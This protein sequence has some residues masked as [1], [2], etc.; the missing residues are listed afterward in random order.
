MS[1]RQPTPVPGRARL[2]WQLRRAWARL[3]T[4]G[5][6]VLAALALWLGLH[7]TVNRPLG[8]EAERLAQ[9]VAEQ[10]R[11]ALPVRGGAATARSR[12]ELVAFFPTLEQRE[13]DLRRLHQ[14]AARQDLA[15]VRADYRSEPLSAL[16]LQRLSLRLQLQGGY[17]RQRLFLQALLREL[18]HLAVERLSLEGAP[19][20]P[21]AM[22][23]LV[24]AH[25]YYQPR[26]VPEG[27]P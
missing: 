5:L 6:C 27:R 18:P 10:Q 8:A 19:G 23:A 2:R 15:L 9:Q 11:T 7:L 1:G 26:P 17:A 22:S 25:L 21:E 4:L 12:H 14:L 13:Q 3:D 20:A 16:P 24:E